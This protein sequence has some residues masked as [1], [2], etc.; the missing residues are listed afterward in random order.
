LSRQNLDPSLSLRDDKLLRPQ[1][2][3][4]LQ[5]KGRLLEAARLILMI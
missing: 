3:L 5:E 4:P 1:A 2:S